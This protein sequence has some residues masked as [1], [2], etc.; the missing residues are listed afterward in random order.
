M[1]LVSSFVLAVLASCGV[2]VRTMPQ[3][4]SDPGVDGGVETDGGGNTT[5]ADARVPPP[6]GIPEG[7]TPCE[8][9]VYHSDF[10]FLQDKVFNEKCTESCHV[11]SKAG[12]FLD[13]RPGQAYGHLIN[14]VSHHDPSWMRVAPGNPGASML[15]VQVG[16]EPGPPLEGL[17]PW[18][19][20]RLCDELVDAMRR[21]IA[22]GAADD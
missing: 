3:D 21:W 11:P 17:M 5:V 14:A 12:A 2:D 15:M 16:G 6:D 20:P 7:L 19:Q 9:A 4:S 8:E 13:L 10:A 18:G 22:A 1:R